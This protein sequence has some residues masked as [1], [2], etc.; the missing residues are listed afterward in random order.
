MCKFKKGDFVARI[1]YNKDVIFEITNI[2][3]TSS[4]KKIYILKGMTRRIVAD[5]F[6]DDLELVDKRIA[7]REIKTVEN[8]ILERMRVAEKYDGYNIKYSNNINLFHIN[9]RKN[10]EEKTIHLGKILHLDG[11]KRYAEKSNK[12]Y[13]SLGLNAVVKNIAENKQSMLIRSLLE[14]YEPDILVITGHDGMI[15]RGMGFNDIYN[16][17]NSRHFINT[18][19]E[20]RKWNMEKKKDLAIFAGAC[21]SFYEAIMSAGANFASSPKRIMIDFID[22]LVVA[23][24]IAM[25]ENTKYLTIGDIE[26]ELRDGRDGVSGTGSMGKKIIETKR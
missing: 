19:K 13:K 23:E 26:E 5:S 7:N 24:R 22:P 16:Y 4:N 8:K 18:V 14:K 12:Y 2:I 3:K 6:E 1:S 25:T 17:R 20:A 15:K 21:Q 9:N 10:D 11:D